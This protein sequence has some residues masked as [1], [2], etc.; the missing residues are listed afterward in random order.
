MLRTQLR[1]ALKEIAER[2]RQRCDIKLAAGD[3]RTE[4]EGSC[5]HG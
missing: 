4:G 1:E 5:Q 3:Q 2:P